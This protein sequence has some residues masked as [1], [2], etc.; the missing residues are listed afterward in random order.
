M[1]APPKFCTACG[2]PLAAGKRFC[3]QCGQPVVL[4]GQP[5][6]TAPETIRAAPVAPAVGGSGER[7]LGIVPFIEQG[8]LSVIHYTLIVTDRRLIFCTWSPESDEAMSD[9]DDAVMQESCDIS[10]TKDEIAHFREKDWAGGPWE[11]YRSMNP[12]AIIAGAP[13]TI[14]IP[15]D[16]IADINIVCETLTST[17]DKLYVR[18]RNREQTF[19]LMYS[20]GPYL[21]RILAPLLGDRLTMEDHLHHRRGLD[22]LLSGQE[23]R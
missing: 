7:I 14:T 21:A 8:L 4:P 17:Q 9:A 1:T 19:D 12:D 23:Y 3:T 6:T 22:R 5:A 11:R 20:Q 10:G 16:E 18:D 2:A 13:G 15:V